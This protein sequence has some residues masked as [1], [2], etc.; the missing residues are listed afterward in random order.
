MKASWKRLLAL[1]LVMTMCLSLFPASALAEEPEEEPVAPAAEETSESA[2]AT[3]EEAD[4]EEPPTAPAFAREPEDGSIPEGETCVFSWDLNFE[5]DRQELLL[6][7]PE[8]AEDGEPVL[9]LVEELPAEARSWELAEPGTY[10]I[11]AWLGEDCALSEPFTLTAEPAAPAEDETAEDPRAELVPE[12][13]A[14]ALPAEGELN[15]SAGT[16]GDNVTWT[17]DDSGTLTISGT[18]DMA[19]YVSTEAAW[20]PA[21]WNNYS[22]E[23]TRVVIR[24]GISSIGVCAFSGCYNMTEVSIPGTV[25]R[26]GDDAF[27]SCGNLAGITVPDSVTAIGDYA[28]AYCTSLT[29]ASLPGGLTQLGSCVFNQCPSLTDLT[30]SGTKAAWQGLAKADTCNRFRVTVHCTDGDLTPDDPTFCGDDLRWTLENGV[31]T[32]SGTG[33]MWDFTPTSTPWYGQTG[34]VTQVVLEPGVTSIGNYA[35]F[36]CDKL[37]AVSIPEGV[38]VIGDGA[39]IACQ[40]LAGITLPDGLRRIGS[41][42]FSSCRQ[43][44]SIAIPEGVTEIGSS[45]FSATNLEVIDLPS[46][47]T[48]LGAYAFE[49]CAVYSVRIPEGVTELKEGTFYACPNLLSVSLPESLTTIGKNAFLSCPSL[50]E[51]FLPAAV[52]E[53]GSAAFD[54]CNGLMS[55]RVAEENTAYGTLDGILYTK[56]LGAL[57]FCPK[58]VAGEIT[59]PDGVTRIESSAFANCGNLTAVKLPDSVTEIGSGAFYG[60]GNLT[61]VRLPEGLSSISGSTFGEC[62]SLRTVNIPG[63]VTEIGIYAFGS[64]GLTEVT[65][66]EGLTRLG[67]A[68]FYRTSDLSGITIPAS[69]TGIDNYAFAYSGLNRIRFEGSA[70]QIAG[71]RTFSDVS[72]TAYYPADDPSWTEAVRQSYGGSLTWESF[73]VTA[74]GP[75]GDAL[76]WTL[77]TDGTL[78][79]SGTGD[80]WNYDWEN[81]PDWLRFYGDKV[82]SLVIREGVTSVGNCAFPNGWYYFAA[83]TLYLPSTLKR[84]GNMAFPG[85]FSRNEGMTISFPAA[86][87]EIG[88]SAFAGSGL[89]GKLTIP[90][91][92]KTIGSDAFGSTGITELVLED[93]VQEVGE[94]AFAG[95]SSL[96]R[97][98]VPASVT[99]VG[100][101]AFD[102]APYLTDL[103]FD[104]TV[105]RWKQVAPAAV[106][107]YQT[108]VHCTDGQILPAAPS[109]CGD[110]L[111]W[112][113]EDG[114]L[115]VSGTGDMWD[116]S[117]LW[118]QQNSGYVSTAP[119]R[120]RAAEIRQVVVLPGVTS[121]GDYAFGLQRYSGSD[122]DQCDQITSLTLPEG[123]T[124]IGICAF[125]GCTGLQSLRLPES[126][127]SIEDW[128]F[129]RCSSLTEL[130]IPQGVTAIGE[131]TFSGCDGLTELT[132]PGGV[133][134]LAP[135]AFGS[136]DNLTRVTVP[137]GVTEGADL[138]F[139]NCTALEEILV[140]E[141][142]S[143]YASRDGMLY[144]KDLGT[145]LCCPGGKSGVILLPPGVRRIGNSAF[146]W[147]EK[148]TAVALPDGLAEIG[149][150]AF[151]L[152][153]QLARVNLPKSL[154]AIGSGAFRNC[155]ALTELILP[156]GLTEIRDSA[157]SGAGLTSVLI[158][159]GVTSIGNDAFAWNSL[160]EIRFEGAAPQI[161][162]DAFSDV[163][164]TAYYLESDPS[165]T[166]AVRQSYGGSLTWTA[167]GPIASGVCGENLTW[168][169]YD[170]GTLAI[171]GTGA[172]TDFVRSESGWSPAPW[173]ENLMEITRVVIGPGATSIGD[174]AFS[175][176]ENLRDVEIPNT[177]TRI[178]LGAFSICC[179]LTHAAIPE[180]VTVLDGDTFDYCMGLTSAYLPASL[181][182]LGDWTFNMCSNLTDVVFGGTR[183]AWQSL[184]KANTCNRYRVTVHCTDGDLTPA[185]PAFCGDDLTWTLENGV[186]TVSGTGAMWDFTPTSTPW[187]GQTGQVTQVVLE[188]GVTSIGNYAFLHCDNLTAVSI[189]DGLVSI[190]DNAFSNCWSLTGVTFPASLTHVGRYAFSYCRQ[191]RRI[192]I[193]AGMTEIGD[194]AFASCGA[195]V[196]NLPEGLK[197]IGEGAFCDT[198]LFSLRVPEGVTEIGN[199]A[200]RES[201]LRNIVLPDSLKTIG[202]S[203][204][205]QC[206][207]L[208]RID[209]PAGVTF[210]GD[211]AFERRGIQEIRVAEENSAYTTLDGILYT[212]DLGALIFCPVGKSGNLILP[213]GLTRIEALA[214]QDCVNL[215]GVLFPESLAEICPLAFL[216]CGALAEI[217]FGGAAPEIGENAFSGVTATAFYPQQDYSWTEAKRQS[218]GGALTWQSYVPANIVANGSCG[219]DLYWFLTEDGNL[220]LNGTGDMYDYSGPYYY[221]GNNYAPWYAYRDRITR[222]TLP[223]GLTG[224]GSFAFCECKY[225]DRLVLPAAVTGIG[226]NAFEG[227]S[228]LRGRLL[229]PPG[230]RSLGE[231]AFSHCSGLTGQLVLPQG[232]TRVER[233]AFYYCSGL[234]GLVVPDSVTD[235]RESAFDGCRSLASVTLPSSVTSFGQSA[236]S[237]SW[238]QRVKVY[239]DDLDWWLALPDTYGYDLPHGDLYLNGS[240]VTEIT[241]PEGTLVL[242]PGMFEKMES[243]RRVKLPES[244]TG[245]GNYAFSQC[246]GLTELVLPAG[247]RSIGSGVFQNCSGLTELELP[248]G[249]ISIGESAFSGCTGL[250]ALELPEGLVSIGNSAFNYCP[251]LTYMSIP[252]G[253]AGIGEYAFSSCNG[254]ARIDFLGDAPT[255]GNWVFSG[256][257]ATALYPEENETWTPEKRQNYDGIITWTPYRSEPEGTPIASALR[258]DANGGIDAPA[259]QYK[260]R[261]VDLEL[262]T[263]VPTRDYHVFR[264]WAADPAAADPDFAPGA[265]YAE[266]GDRTLYAVWAPRTWALRYQP[267]GGTGAPAPQT[268]TY[269]Q[270]LT[271]AESVPEREGYDFLGWST[272]YWDSTPRYL[273]G[274]SFAENGDPNSDEPILLYA[275]WQ[276]RSYLILYK[277]NGGEDAPAP[278]IKLHGRALTLAQEIPTRDGFRFLGW[279]TDRKAVA[280]EYQPGDRFTAN[281][282][283]VLYAVWAAGS[284]T[285]SYD[286]NGGEGAP[287]AQPKAQNESLTLS[288]QIPTRAGNGNRS[289][290]VSLDPN[291]GSV[292]VDTL[293]TQGS[294]S[295]VF[296][297][298]NTAPDGSGQRYFPGGTYSDNA[299]AT[300]Y[301]QWT[302]NVTAEPVTLPTPTRE[303]FSFQGWARSRTAARGVTGSYQPAGDETLYAIWQ[304]EL[305]EDDFALL[306][307]SAEARPT[308]T[309]TLTLRVQNNPGLKGISAMLAYDESAVKLVSAETKIAFGTWM[310]DNIAEDRLIYWYSTDSFTG[311]EVIKLTFQVLETAAEGTYAIELRLGEW[312]GICG[313]DGETIEDTVLVPGTL[314]VTRRI[315]G[316]ITG[317]GKVNISDV[318]R[319]AEYVKARGKDVEIVPGSGDVNADGRVNISD[320]IRLAEYVKA[321]GK[322]VEIH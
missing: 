248:A 306:L 66:P 31:L 162:G 72:A 195:E 302:A 103:S 157:F 53:I 180:S 93:G 35:F 39:F 42:A 85:C 245:M 253:V 255:F 97:V 271:L 110:D 43:L 89:S 286:A 294:E 247:V 320:V 17:L 69:V 118:D 260:G 141:G 106:N 136:C 104:G 57:I 242:R 27:S 196:V 210:I 174:Y 234:T 32:V 240:L 223:E 246:T 117:L 236:F 226:N 279:S 123:L 12:D 135:Y 237:D 192:D 81:S 36:C 297:A 84:I 151:S 40:S 206:Y 217:R 314:T 128:A 65:L 249:L 292:S 131:Y 109:A 137:A 229:L 119:W 82:K 98:S 79:I 232:L 235:I 5:P 1:V 52:T 51:L 49:N 149:D 115:T 168:A 126:V 290:T 127:T 241:V 73:G 185:D 6:Q 182:Q 282:S 142:N 166:E 48:S 147:N 310:V 203:A 28:F 61:A 186:L 187:Y 46:T 261:G 112:T 189:P 33:A 205:A 208:S 231:Y 113:L 80:M 198:G 258:Y 111:T 167:Y 67:E 64:S 13:E 193:P 275:V 215:T 107:R 144:T 197:R 276:L 293:S 9:T 304:P 23:I 165:W 152:C 99:S 250:T 22:D 202:A 211:H 14:E 171:S 284:Y 243:L 7:E 265:L 322:D 218:Y 38:T 21:P 318:I 76:T 298:W 16:C 285:V 86:L 239:I 68:A 47:L 222:L 96:L 252:A 3:G 77:Y 71:D 108:T 139:A 194:Y 200:F 50:Q 156:A 34:Q 216:N 87:T 178:G 105:A 121:V 191:I 134:S 179:S 309:F 296:S 281:G 91:M 138:A 158:P 308:E 283:T 176:C 268:K 299:S 15:A 204:F 256:V 143:A 277:A 227:C 129:A 225:I 270:P 25:T 267:S 24:P 124:R 269:D 60:C 244:L 154:T 116:F 181:T 56:D 70:P 163:T 146:S 177:V 44:Q 11:R 287:E 273:P 220:I 8:P 78:V 19:D 159:A 37:T 251:A 301:A 30:F 26:I 313:I 316:D 224:I 100:T 184:A 92:V 145:L 188:P 58:S 238:D 263:D 214:F 221:P 289:F 312:D 280:P 130:T 114:V 207:E 122:L 2:E 199:L 307:G 74:S 132:I 291:G 83:E 95:C 262:T 213:D 201:G 29:E 300:L 272:F 173:Q 209:I 288:S 311:Q 94:E 125:N 150:S 160:K 120:S 59:V 148:I 170:N 155:S 212:K 41:S 172:M 88:D 90:G 10:R 303:G 161:A 55:I 219:A 257:R 140:A 190:G 54:R 254:L 228:G 18:G 305:S 133:R 20:N 315:P 101:R 264:G 266:D 259:T 295:F 321:R 233:Y 164:A 4:A 317:D 169:L 319:L 102:S 45:A 75:C 175:G 278:Q 153:S 183:A 63:S 230:L 62:W 274:D